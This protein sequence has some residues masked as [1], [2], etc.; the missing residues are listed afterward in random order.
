MKV[1]CVYFTF[2][3]TSILG[4]QEPFNGMKAEL[5]GIMF[6]QLPRLTHGLHTRLMGRMSKDIPRTTHDMNTRLLGIMSKHVNRS[7]TYW[8]S[9]SC[10]RNTIHGGG[11]RPSENGGLGG[12]APQQG[13]AKRPQKKY[14]PSK[15]PQRETPKR[16]A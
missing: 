5:L 2:Y 13:A 15:R 16:V 4:L 14:D 8:A 7:D 9:N 10:P 1:S 6:T 3:R 11:W 12:V